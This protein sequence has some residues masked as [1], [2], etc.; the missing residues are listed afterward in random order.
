MSDTREWTSLFHS[1]RGFRMP[2]LQKVLKKWSHK[3]VKYLLMQIVTLKLMVLPVRR[4]CFQVGPSCFVPEYLSI[5]N[6]LS[7]E[8]LLGK[9]NFLTAVWFIAWCDSRRLL[10]YGHIGQYWP[11]VTLGVLGRCVVWRLVTAQAGGH[12]QEAN[13]STH[14]QSWLFPMYFKAKFPWRLISLMT[15]KKYFL[16]AY[17]VSGGLLYLGRIFLLCHCKKTHIL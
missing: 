4:G 13:Q 8:S 2:F 5:Q 3:S 6:G 16:E 12:L 17:R 14:D 9:I 10:F 7:S 1:I 15:R 11:Q